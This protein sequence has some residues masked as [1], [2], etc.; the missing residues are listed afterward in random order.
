MDMHY[1]L[2]AAIPAFSLIRLLVGS[3]FL[4]HVRACY[5]LT[6]MHKKR[7]NPSENR[8]FI[9]LSAVGHQLGENRTFLSRFILSLAELC[10]MQER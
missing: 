5:M 7:R 6:P 2:D 1:E 10:R 9:E 8:V 3:F 4:A